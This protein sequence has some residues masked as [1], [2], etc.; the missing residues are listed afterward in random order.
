MA[1]NESVKSGLDLFPF[2][3]TIVLVGA[4]FGG[5]VLIQD[6]IHQ[7]SMVPYGTVTAAI[8]ASI[9]MW[10]LLRSDF[11]LATLSTLGVAGSLEMATISTAFKWK[12]ANLEFTPSAL[13]FVLL[14]L[15]FLFLVLSFEIDKKKAVLA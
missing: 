9:T 12:E 6:G 5:L 10:L 11:M 2:A 3:V 4:L 14:V 8:M 13:S 1:R 7:A 15:F